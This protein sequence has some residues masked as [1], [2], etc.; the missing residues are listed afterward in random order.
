MIAI[1]GWVSIR[2]C[3]ISIHMQFFECRPSDFTITTDSKESIKSW[4]H[5]GDAEKSDLYS[6]IILRGH[7]QVAVDESLA[8]RKYNDC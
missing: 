5:Y 2:V 6:G 1:L 4:P 8:E 7:P 3:G